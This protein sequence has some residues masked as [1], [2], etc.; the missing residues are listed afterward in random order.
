[1]H[2]LILK[3]QY[4]AIGVLRAIIA[5]GATAGPGAV[6]E[7][8]MTVGLTAAHGMRADPEAIP[9][10]AED[11]SPK[12]EMLKMIAPT[13]GAPSLRQQLLLMI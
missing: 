11:P 2:L 10:I 13:S 8:T 7:G 12:V 1:M 5:H 9:K 6:Q 4:I 3:D